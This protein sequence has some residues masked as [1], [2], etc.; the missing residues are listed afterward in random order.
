MK[1]LITLKQQINLSAS[2][3]K[4]FPKIENFIKKINEFKTRKKQFQL[5]TNYDSYSKKKNCLKQFQAFILVQLHAKKIEPH[6]AFIHH[7]L[8]K[9]PF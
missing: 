4:T 9:A 8:Q 5:T 7:K 6:H 2:H 3:S 1:T